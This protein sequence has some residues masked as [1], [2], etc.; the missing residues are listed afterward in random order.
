MEN[1]FELTNALKSKNTGK[2]LRLLGNQLKHG[3]E[4]LKILGAIIWQFRF[5][6]EVRHHFLQRIPTAQIARAMGTRPFVV[7]KALPF[8]EAFSQKE[9]R[10]GFEILFQAD[11]E[12]KTTGREP[13]RVLEGLILE[14]GSAG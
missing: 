7:E 13:E 3:E 14:L 11:R 12:L 1:A 5:I 4:P 8:A 2:A 6:W 9:L 10:K